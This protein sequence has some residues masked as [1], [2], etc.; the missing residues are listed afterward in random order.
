MS[1]EIRKVAN[2]FIV[3]PPRDITRDFV[4]DESAVHVFSTW[5]KASAWINDQFKK[6]GA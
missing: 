4:V 3:L 6:A 1:F 5:Q 2:G